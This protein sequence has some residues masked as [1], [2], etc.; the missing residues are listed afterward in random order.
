[1][2]RILKIMIY[3]ILVIGYINLLIVGYGHICLKIDPNNYDC[4]GI[5]LCFMVYF[6]YKEYL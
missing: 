3:I 5:I 2:K 6:N 4:L 1:M